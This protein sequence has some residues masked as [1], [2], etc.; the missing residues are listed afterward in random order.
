MRKIWSVGRKLIAWG[1]LFTLIGTI[2]SID[3]KIQ[4]KIG[5]KKP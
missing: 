2:W 5:K 1:M 4:Q 3:G